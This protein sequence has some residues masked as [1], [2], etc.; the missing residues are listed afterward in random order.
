MTVW[1]TGAAGM[2]GQEVV[3]QLSE[4][5]PGDRIIVIATD[6]E[7]DITSA[8]AVSAFWDTH[9]KIDWIVNCAAWT[10]VDAAEE[11]EEQA[12]LLNVEGPRVLASAAETR[13][14]AMVHIS[15]DYVFSGNGSD[16]Y[17][18]KDPTDPQSVYGRTKCDGEQAVRDAL[19]RHI[20][21]RTAWLYG[22]A[23]KN[24]VETMIR[25][26]NERD[27]IGVVADQYGLPTYAPDL[28]SAIRTIVRSAGANASWGT[29]HYTN[30][31]VPGEE[32]TGISWHTFAQTIYELARASGAISSTCTINALT[33][34]QYPT[35]AARPA[36]SVL[37]CTETEATTGM[38]RPVWTDS[39]SRYLDQRSNAGV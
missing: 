11:H 34:E 28:A 32:T 13:G 21:I 30:A 16:P 27:E 24:F 10:A 6:R 4:D 22:P 23:G 39:L 7:I 20:I 3:R 19:S 18:P 12:T 5:H 37:D 14:A 29:F 36:Y 31:P 1:V 17:Q 26:M 8:D 33:T 2:L 9:G 35:P 15:T 25:L 38:E